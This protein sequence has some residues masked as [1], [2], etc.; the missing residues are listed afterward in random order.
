L[1]GWSQSDAALWLKRRIVGDQSLDVFMG[2]KME[3]PRQREVEDQRL[4]DMALT[5][6][7]DGRHARSG[8]S[9]IFAE[10]NMPTPEQ[11]AGDG[12]TRPAVA[13][14]PGLRR[15]VLLRDGVEVASAPAPICENYYNYAHQHW[16]QLELRKQGATVEFYCEGDSAPR[17]RFVDPQ[18][19]A[20][21]VP[22]IWTFDNGIMIAR[23][24]LHFVAPAELR[25][26]PQ[27][28][29][30]RP[31]Y[32]EFAD[33]QQPIS[34][35]F[36]DSWST[37]GQPVKLQVVAR[38]VP[39]G[40]DS[41][42]T[43][44]GLQVTFSPHKT[45]EHWYQIYAVD[46][47]NNTSAPFD[48]SVPV[49][50][51]RLKRDDSHALALYRFD[52]GSGSI[53]RDHGVISPAA[54]ITI[55][56]AANAHW[57]A[58]YGLSLHGTTPALTANSVRKFMALAKGKAFT[59]ELWVSTDTIAPT[60]DVCGCML[61][62]ESKNLQRNFS[63]GQNWYDLYFDG[64]RLN[65]DHSKGGYA[66]CTAP[67]SARPWLQHLVFS[68]ANRQIRIYTNGV[69]KF[70]G[71]LSAMSLDHW[72]PDAVLLLGNYADGS[73]S[74]LGTYYLVALH[75]KPFTDAEVKH[76]YLAGPVAR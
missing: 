12:G 56:K 71:P 16:F 17:L 32:P 42:V 65:V 47:D 33:A 20:G 75:N 4:R 53:V 43:V 39:D 61:S 45:G 70:T 55:P 50:D 31:G 11:T 38:A 6:C 63:V 23:A 57:V 54:N 68:V 49:F 64:G 34:L 19:I 1:A 13:G 5:I 2:L 69:E 25:Q 7:G 18:P 58:P 74:Y 67:D 62:W 29:L 27:V 60:T 76:N 15:I 59:I 10:S 46:A 36:H 22:A 72:S 3:Y 44:H 41:A 37:T 30:A 26:D 73:A 14:A 24:R 8:Y 48:L 51:P 66:Y 21:G 28:V 40:E 9:V 35:D 52:E